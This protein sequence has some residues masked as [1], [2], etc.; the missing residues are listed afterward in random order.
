[1]QHSAGSTCGQPPT[2]RRRRSCRRSVALEAKTSGRSRSDRRRPGPEPWITRGEGAS[3]CQYNGRHCR[4]LTRQSIILTE[5]IDARA[6]SAHDKSDKT[7]RLRAAVRAATSAWF[8][9]GCLGICAALSIRRCRV[10]DRTHQR[11][12]ETVVAP[13]VH[14][15]PIRRQEYLEGDAVNV[16]PVPH[17]REAVK[18]VDV[19]LLGRTR[20]ELDNVCNIRQS[21]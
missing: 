1:M 13:V 11:I 6:I 5:K 3:T 8:F 10:A 21:G 12:G 14:M 19:L 4:D 17:E 18:H 9:R 2:G 15:Q 16:V 7:R 20:N